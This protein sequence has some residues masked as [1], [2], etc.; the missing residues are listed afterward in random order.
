MPLSVAPGVRKAY[1]AAMTDRLLRLLAMLALLLMPAKMAAAAPGGQALPAASV[2][3]CD[4]HGP[5]APAPPE[6]PAHCVSCSALPAAE[7]GAPA[8]SARPRAPVRLA[9]ATPIAGIVPEIATPP[10]RFS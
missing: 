1:P 7:L 8:L 4:D 3:H 9:R 10:P 2:G 6:M 5:Q